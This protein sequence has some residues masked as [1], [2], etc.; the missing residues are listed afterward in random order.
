MVE[1]CAS[2][3]AHG[4][5]VVAVIGS[6]TGGTAAALQRAG[7][8]FVARTQHMF[9]WRGPVNILLRL[10]LRW[11]AR[12]L[13]YVLR[14]ATIA[15]QSLRL[16]WFLRRSRIDIV[17]AQVYQSIVIGRLAAWLA[18]VPIRVAMVPGPWHMEVPKLRRISI[19]TQWIDSA[20][21]GG[22]QRVDD[23]HAEA[24]I[25]VERR[26]VIR[27]GADHT[28]FD[29]ARANGERFRVE[30]GLEAGTPL[31]GQ[32][33]YFYPRQ[34]A[35]VSPPVVGDRG[36]K[37]HDDFL[38][39]AR[40][41]LDARPDVRFA[42]VGGGW[43]ELGEEHRQE[44]IQLAR[45]LGLADAVIFAGHRTDIPDVLA[46][47]DVSVQCSL[48]ENYGGTIESLLMERPTIATRV[49]GMPEAVRDGETGLLVPPRDPEALAAAMLRLIDD[50]ELG[51]R[52]GRAGR[53]LM[54]SGFTTQAMCN[55]VREL[56]EEL[57]REKLPW[58]TIPQ[59]R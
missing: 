20:T 55:G 30:L 28:V 4:Y 34:P 1:M 41:V 16:A 53:E 10:R 54:L 8:P 33:A 42:L 40:I 59:P 3:Q 12:P 23:L 35:R 44:M 27:Y 48:N 49:G 14:A 2:L 43:T 15:N 50:P 31:V 51:A 52:L 11:I 22:S 13:S 7:V 47:L 36:V 5:D 45:N 46:A 32:V 17:H 9:G 29:P 25:P 37:G 58:K 18:R 56:Y 38:A 6:T 21:V 39:A 57:L 19:W 26:R 24:G